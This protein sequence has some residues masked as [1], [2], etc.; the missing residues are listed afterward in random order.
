MLLK[1]GNRGFSAQQHESG[2]CLM[3]KKTRI[4]G[5]AINM[6]STYPDYSRLPN[7]PVSSE[8]LLG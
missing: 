5:F 2:D 7:S 1:G 6:K 4:A 8:A 3:R